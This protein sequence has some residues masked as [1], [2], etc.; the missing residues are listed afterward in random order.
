MHDKIR[1]SETNEAD[2]MKNDSVEKRIGLELGVWFGL[3]W[4]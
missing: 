4:I 3:G 2:Q 1:S